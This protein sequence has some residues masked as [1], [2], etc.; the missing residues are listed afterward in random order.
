M[1]TI[2]I[3][4]ENE[5]TSNCIEPDINAV[6]LFLIATTPQSRGNILKSLIWQKYF[7]MLAV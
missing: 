4:A 3:Q 2:W 7:D 6:L 1:G 5:C